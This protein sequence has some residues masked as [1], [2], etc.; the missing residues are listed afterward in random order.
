VVDSLVSGRK[1]QVKADSAVL[2]RIGRGT[3][4]PNTNNV[5]VEGDVKD[6]ASC[7]DVDKRMANGAASA[8]SR[9]VENSYVGSRAGLGND[10][11][12]NSS[13]KA[14]EES[15]SREMHLQRYLCGRCVYE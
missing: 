10:Q 2:A 6:G 8:D 15:N 9:D 5:L 4:G 12:W 1:L 14:D 3:F 11:G 13:G 7:V